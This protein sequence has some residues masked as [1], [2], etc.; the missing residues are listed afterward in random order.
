MI[1]LLFQC[2][3][4]SE[5][6]HDIRLFTIGCSGVK[7]LAKY[8]LVVPPILIQYLLG[9]YSQVSEAILP[10]CPHLFIAVTLAMNILI[11]SLSCVNIQVVVPGGTRSDISKLGFDV[12]LIMYSSRSNSCEF[13]GGSH[14]IVMLSDSLESS[15]FNER[16]CGRSGISACKYI[17]VVYTVW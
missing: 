7:C 2:G 12:I 11:C 13:L 17:T 3:I 8:I 5:Y 15:N 16:F 9:V 4:N 1:S 10:V 14:I 6:Q